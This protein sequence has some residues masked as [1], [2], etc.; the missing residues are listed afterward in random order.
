MAWGAGRLKSLRE[1]FY[2]SPR[3]WGVQS[4]RVASEWFVRNSSDEE[5]VSLRFKNIYV[6]ARGDSAHY[7]LALRILALWRLKQKD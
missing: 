4:G 7:I 3:D 5:D 2:N 1:P 6:K